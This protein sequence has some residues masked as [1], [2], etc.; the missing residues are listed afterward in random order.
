[1]RYPRASFVAV[2][3]SGAVLGCSASLPP[4]PPGLP[5]T[6]VTVTVKNPGGD[7]ADPEWAALDRLGHEPW[8]ARRDRP[9]TL[10][11][12]LVDARHWQRVR[13]W[14]YPTRTAFR[15]GDDHYGVVAVWYQATTE[16]DDPES[17][18]ARFVAEARPA[19]EAYGTRVVA[20]RVMHTTQH[21]GPVR[22]PMVL[23]V[24]D[25]DV[26]GIFGGRSYAGALAA[27]QSWPGT[28]LIQGFVV[29][30]AKHRE[31]AA[32]VRDR[33]VAEGAQRL[34]WQPRLLEAP[35]FED[36]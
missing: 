28:C 17:C 36:H 4:R 2:T 29:P 1:M 24:I 25:A 18:L 3:L 12:A 7:A 35:G 26:E 16:N 9:N 19:A 23:Q 30:S 33:W 15:F 20:S 11:I 8:G 22:R 27:Y 34:L 14:G 13:L 10:S 32:R 5:P 6:P 21:L 31:L